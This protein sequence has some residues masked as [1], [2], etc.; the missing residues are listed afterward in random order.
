MGYTFD[1]DKVAVMQPLDVGF[2]LV[3]RV[4]LGAPAQA[5]QGRHATGGS[6]VDEG[7]MC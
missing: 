1:S 4:P 6:C 3:E 7:V 5:S 2:G